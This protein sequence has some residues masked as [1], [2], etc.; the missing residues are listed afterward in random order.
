MRVDGR[1][2]QGLYA[3]GVVI[4]SDTWVDLRSSSYSVTGLISEDDLLRV[5]WSVRQDLL[6]W[7]AQ[8]TDALTTAMNWANNATALAAVAEN[9]ECEDRQCPLSPLCKDLPD[10]QCVV[11]GRT[12]ACSSGKPVCS[13]PEP[14]CSTYAETCIVV[15][16]TC[17]DTEDDECVT[18]N[19]ECEETMNVCTQWVQTCEESPVGSCG[20]YKVSEDLDGCQEYLTSCDYDP[21]SDSSC[22]SA[23]LQSQA[24]SKIADTL[25]ASYNSS[26]NRVNAQLTGFRTLNSL[27]PLN[28]YN[29]YSI[30]SISIVTSLDRPG[31]GENDVE[32]RVVYQTLSLGTLQLETVEVV[33]NWDFQQEVLNEIRLFRAAKEY[34]VNSRANVLDAR[35]TTMTPFEVLIETFFKS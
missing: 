31:V 29:M 9:D 27:L 5:A 32:V 8:G 12:Q 11:H 26:M 7:V 2:F 35:L 25:A 10:T 16:T 4:V 33:I 18:W 19:T 23:C 30:E 28:N 21:R 1:P 13:T 20:T 34:I 14:T 3:V 6:Y 22:V 24:Q 15:T 17:S